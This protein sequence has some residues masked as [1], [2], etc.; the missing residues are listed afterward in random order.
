MTGRLEEMDEMA[1]DG[2]HR[3][4]PRASSIAP[5]ALYQ[6][7]PSPA[8]AESAGSPG[9]AQNRRRRCPLT[10]RERLRASASLNN[11]A[12]DGPELE[13]FTARDIEPASQ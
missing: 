1:L 9:S 7:H 10:E 3:R 12:G 13:R 11:K 5:L 6:N 8:A 2:S 4:Q